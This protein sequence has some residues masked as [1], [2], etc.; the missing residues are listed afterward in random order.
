MFVFDEPALALIAHL[1]TREQDLDV[2]EGVFLQRQMERMK[3]HLARYPEQVH[4]DKA[5]DWIARY[6]AQYR[7]RWR[8]R[9]ANQPDLPTRCT[10]CPMN[11]LGEE[12]PCQIHDEWMQL[13]ACYCREELSSTEYVKRALALLREHKLELKEQKQREAAGLQELNAYRNARNQPL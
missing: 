13:L 1:V 10:N 11:S 6:A 12:N 4:V 2:T 5:I 9:T 8:T 7:E 3:C